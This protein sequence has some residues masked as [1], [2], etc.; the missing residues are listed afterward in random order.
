[1]TSILLLARHY[2]PAVSGGARRP[3]L[4]VE[5]LRELGAQV[6]VVAP[7][8]PSG[9]DGSLGLV[10]PHPNRDPSTAPAHRPCRSLKDHARESLLWPDP[11][12]RWAM[13]AARAAVDAVPF[14]PDWV[15]TTSPPE[16]LHV[17]GAWLKRRLGARWA[18]DFRDTW[19]YRPHRQQRSH[20]LR[21]TGEALIARAILPRA[22]LVLAVDPV[23]AREIRGLGAREAV[24]LPHFSPDKLPPPATLLGE[25]LNVVH[26]GSIELSDPTARIEDLL[27]TFKAAL[28]ENPRLHLHLVGRLSHREQL[29]AEDCPE[30][31]L[32]GPKSYEDALALIGAADALALVASP[33]MHVPPSKIVDYLATDRPILACGEGEWRMDPRTPKSSAL[34]V[35]RN[36]RKG[37][38]RAEA[39]PAPKGTRQ[40]AEDL[41]SLMKQHSG[42]H[43]P[44]S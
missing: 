33:K 10:V 26:A 34:D 25:N 19:L 7:S 40:T 36:L 23:V 28:A 31:T 3:G 27:D 20:P 17:A 44:G 16:S 9:D 22:D 14:K 43:D 12:V 30:V 15:L 42:P 1:M 2:P 32:H 6:F 41:L 24:V 18:A 8:L 4:L 39:L 29:L 13:R 5:A 37:G 38:R 35:L 21:R 11:D